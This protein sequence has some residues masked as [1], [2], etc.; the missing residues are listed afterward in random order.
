[1]PPGRSDICD[2]CCDTSMR[3]ACASLQTACQQH[4]M[5][6]LDVHNVAIGAQSWC[7]L[8]QEQQ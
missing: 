5:L 7:T 6:M 8:A 4:C 1:M 2:G 3:P